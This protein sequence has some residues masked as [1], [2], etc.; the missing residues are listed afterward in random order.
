MLL[1]S[2]AVARA[3]RR[4][5]R[6]RKASLKRPNGDTN[7]SVKLMDLVL[8]AE[9]LHEAKFVATFQGVCDRYTDHAY[10][11]TRHAQ[12]RKSV[13]LPIDCHAWFTS[14]NKGYSIDFINRLRHGHRALSGESF[15]QLTADD[16]YTLPDVA[17]KQI[18]TIAPGIARTNGLDGNPKALK[19]ERAP[20]TPD[21][22]GE[23]PGANESAENVA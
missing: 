23:N 7:R 2:S 19:L 5:V 17:S 3:T 9:E 13:S 20:N 21:R 16:R 22:G 15:F 12:D 1:G 6:Y 4:Y 14:S 10:L 11:A 18:G 8:K